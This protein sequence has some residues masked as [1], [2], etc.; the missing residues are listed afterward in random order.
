M[1][2]SDRRASGDRGQV[3]L[4]GE[5]QFW[6][7]ADHCHACRK[8]DGFFNDESKSHAL[9]VAPIFG[10]RYVAMLLRSTAALW[11]D[12]DPTPHQAG[13]WLLA[14]F[15]KLTATWHSR[16]FQQCLKAAQADRKVLAPLLKS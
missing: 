4:F 9:R 13:A 2:Q 3:E 11:G 16:V 5:T 14:I 1:L 8:D 15:Q 10:P 12:R 6:T 7:F